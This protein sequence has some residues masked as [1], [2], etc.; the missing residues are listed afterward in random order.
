MNFRLELNL[1]DFMAGLDEAAKRRIPRALADALNHTASGARL[2]LQKEMD[3][4]FRPK[5]TPYIRNSVRTTKAEDARLLAD[6]YI[7]DKEPGLGVLSPAQILWPQVYGGERSVKTSENRLRSTGLMGLDQ[8]AVPGIGAPRD[9]Y[10]N[11]SGGQMQRILGFIRAYSESGYNKTKKTG[12]HYV[13]PFVGIF[14]RTGKGG[15]SVPVLH[16]TYA[17]PQYQP[18]FDF[19]YVMTAFVKNN[20]LKNVVLAW[21]KINLK[22]G[23]YGR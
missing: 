16:F 7:S 19:K 3:D 23:Y 20:L 12:G 14:K 4:V 6:V 8:Y 10:G 21:G 22:A 17:R 9:A 1:K 11:I 18:L 5:P 13:I 15:A 2:A